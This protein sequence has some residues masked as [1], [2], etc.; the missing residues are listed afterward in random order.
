VFDQQPAAIAAAARAGVAAARAHEHPRAFQLVTVQRELEV[1]LLQR[2]VHIVHLRLP[3]AAVPQH[4]DA[5]TVAFG[6]HALELAVLDRVILDL[7]RE[8]LRLRIEGRSFGDGP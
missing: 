2:R 7:H 4:H 1:A 8:P 3:C 5:G 6:N